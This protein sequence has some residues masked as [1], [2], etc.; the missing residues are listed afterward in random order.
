MKESKLFVCTA[1][2]SKSKSSCALT[3]SMHIQQ[4]YNDIHNFGALFLLFFC[5]ITIKEYLSQTMIFSE[6]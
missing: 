1:A 4:K 5:R 2:E 6:V 3:V